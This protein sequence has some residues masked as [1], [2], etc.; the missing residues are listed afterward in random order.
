M[1]S[2]EELLAMLNEIALIQKDARAQIAAHKRAA[3]EAES[4]LIE[5]NIRSEKLK[6]E[7]RIY[8][9]TTVSYEKTIEEKNIDDFKLRLPELLK[10]IK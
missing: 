9:I 4:V 7:L 8:R 3:L 6:E 5:A 1:T 10:K 2:E